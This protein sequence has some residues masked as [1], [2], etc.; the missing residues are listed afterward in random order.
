MGKSPGAGAPGSSGR[1]RAVTLNHPEK[2]RPIVAAL[3]LRNRLGLDLHPR[4]DDAL[5]PRVAV[6]VTL[7]VFR[8]MCR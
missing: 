5:D 2:A 1:F 4:P 8:L 6:G 7:I 3:G